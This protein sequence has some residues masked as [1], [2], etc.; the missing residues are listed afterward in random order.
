M[1]H[2]KVESNLN[3]YQEFYETKKNHVSQPYRPEKIIFSMYWIEI[4]Q[5]TLFVSFSKY[6]DNENENNSDSLGNK[7]MTVFNNTV[8]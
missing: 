6:T 1:F 4:D 3:G 7:V 2:L 5:S 8:K